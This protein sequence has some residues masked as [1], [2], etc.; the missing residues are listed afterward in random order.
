M[1]H[2]GELLVTIEAARC[3]GCGLKVC[4]VD[5]GS[6]HLFCEAQKGPSAANAI[7]YFP[8]QCSEPR[9]V[10]K[11]KRYFEELRLPQNKVPLKVRVDLTFE[12]EGG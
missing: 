5:F 11:L 3:P 7:H 8:H 10:G 1:A 2:D 6:T 4:K 12:P 9:F